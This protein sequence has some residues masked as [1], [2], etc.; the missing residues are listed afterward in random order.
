M[1]PILLILMTQGI[2][3]ALDVVINH[4]WREGLPHRSTAI[5][6]EAIHGMR[7]VL[8]AVVFAGL[9]W[10]EWHG[11]FALLFACILLI[12]VLLTAWDFIEEDRT[13]HLSATERVMHLALS[14]GGGAYCALLIPILLRWQTE[15]TGLI[16]VDYGVVSWILSVMAIGVLGWGLRDLIAAWSMSSGVCSKTT[17]EAI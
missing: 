13:R 8:Y 3:G 17:Q 5:L 9:A 1:V 16:T 10:F 7:E 2:L 15:S 14:M 11:A 6:E 12:E 4:E